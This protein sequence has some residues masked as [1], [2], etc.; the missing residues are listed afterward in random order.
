MAFEGLR[1]QDL[2]RWR[3]HHLIVK[4]RPLGAKFVQADYPEIEVDKNIYIDEEGYIDP[5]QL[6]LPD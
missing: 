1:K 3:A 6:S 4:Q 5:S 2:L